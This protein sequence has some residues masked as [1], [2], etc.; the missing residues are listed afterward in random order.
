MIP[1]GG[2]LSVDLDSTLADTSHRRGI[3][4]KFRAAGQPID[5]TEYAMACE[6]DAPTPVVVLILAWQRMGGSWHV[7]SGRSEEARPAT[8]KWLE[9]RGL[10]PVS[11]NLEDDTDS[12]ST[13][14]HTAWKCK[15]V[16]WLAQKYPIFAHVDDYPEV[17]E[18]LTRHS[19]VA[20]ITVMPPGH[21]SMHRDDPRWPRDNP[22]TAL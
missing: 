11:V 13:L 20:G 4:E 17:G 15:R 10:E 21:V 7:V 9:G 12:H 16:L 5:W 8:E 14:G 1:F 6:N 22:E 3:I 18:W 2:H 19:H